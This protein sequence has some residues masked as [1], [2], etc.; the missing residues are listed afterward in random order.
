MNEDQLFLL[1][2]RLYFHELERRERLS[3]RLNVPL[4]ILVSVV[5]FLAFML[6]TA[7]RHLDGWLAIGFWM[8][9]CSAAASCGVGMWFFRRAWFGHADKL[10]PTANRTETYRQEVARLYEPYENA[11]ELTAAAMKRYFYEYYMRVSSDNTANNDQR[12]YDIYRATYAISVA[13]LL[14]FLAFVPFQLDRLQ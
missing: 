8:L 9:F 5:G 12:S 14:A 3:A 4:A 2:E 1:Y 6:Q 10:L 11:V 13:V 7:P